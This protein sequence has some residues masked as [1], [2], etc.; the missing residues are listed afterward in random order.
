MNVNDRIA[1]ILDR[2][3]EF[4]PTIKMSP[5]DHGA[6]T[7]TG[8]EHRG[9]K[10]GSMKAKHASAKTGES[11]APPGVI[12]EDPDAPVPISVSPYH[13][14]KWQFEHAD[15]PIKILTVLL[16][17]ERTLEKLDSPSRS[18]RSDAD[19]DRMMEGPL[20][21]R[22]GEA[23]AHLILTRY[24][25]YL[26]DAVDTLENLKPGTTRKVRRDNNC[27][28]EG[29]WKKGVPRWAY[30]EFEK[31]DALGG[32]DLCCQRFQI[33]PSSYRR[34]RKAI[35]DGEPVQEPKAKASP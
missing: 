28:D 1:H 9:Q 22:D 12:F 14:F 23:I 27:D 26:S 31:L 15:E 18:P 21:T 17:A 11:P 16:A 20:P 6:A 19:E 25:G 35:H 29:H 33:H 4:E 32:Q 30:G 34:I 3:I 8:P 5:W 7:E 10:I 2:L 24:E 13:H